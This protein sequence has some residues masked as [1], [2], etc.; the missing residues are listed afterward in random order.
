VALR[1]GVDV[2]E[3]GVQLHVICYDFPEG[4]QDLHCLPH[5]DGTLLSEHYHVGFMHPDVGVEELPLSSGPLPVDVFTGISV[6]LLMEPSL[7]QTY[8]RQ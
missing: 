4:P 2:P 6:K 8:P 7:S 5:G 1:V 3:P